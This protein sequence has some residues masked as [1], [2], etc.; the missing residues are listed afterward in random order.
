[1]T[2]GVCDGGEFVEEEFAGESLSWVLGFVVFDESPDGCV[3]C[4]CEVVG[5]DVVEVDEGAWVAAE[6]TTTVA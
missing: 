2:L 5:V 6:L 4:V 1:M 3:A